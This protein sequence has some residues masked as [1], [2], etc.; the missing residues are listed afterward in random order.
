M[1]LDFCSCRERII[2]FLQIRLWDSGLHTTLVPRWIHWPH[3][4]TGRTPF[5]GSSLKSRARLGDSEDPR[6]PVCQ[7]IPFLLTMLWHPWP[8]M[9]P[10]SLRFYYLLLRVTDI[11]SFLRLLP[12]SPAALSPL[13][14]LSSPPLLPVHLWS[15]S[16]LCSPSQLPIP[17]P[18]L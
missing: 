2:P 9:A 13:A 18:A 15:Q 10:P 12:P 7:E 17:L 14:L 16:C 6:D 1:S 5:V 11:L 8:Q 4:S 3:L